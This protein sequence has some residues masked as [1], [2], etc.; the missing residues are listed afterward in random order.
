MRVFVII[1]S[2]FILFTAI[3]TA[4]VCYSSYVNRF[5]EH[6]YTP[7]EVFSNECAKRGGNP[8]TNVG[9]KDGI[10]VQEYKCEVAK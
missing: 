7:E 6:V 5:K 4:G 9:W 1:A 8:V 10:H 2:F 3:I